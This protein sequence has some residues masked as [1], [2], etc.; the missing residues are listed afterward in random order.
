[1][2][3]QHP[4]HASEDSQGAS[5]A[6]APRRVLGKQ[7]SDRIEYSGFRLSSKIHHKGVEL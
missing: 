6:G 5:R 2:L 7:A 3:T 1:M 4:Q